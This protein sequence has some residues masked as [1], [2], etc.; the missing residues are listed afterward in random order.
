MK[1][2]FQKNNKK[3]FDYFVVNAFC[4]NRA[5]GSMFECCWDGEYCPV[6]TNG[7]NYKIHFVE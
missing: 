1:N 7:V 6:F 2:W 3:I 5:D 4:K